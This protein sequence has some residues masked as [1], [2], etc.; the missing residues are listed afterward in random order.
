MDDSAFYC[1]KL[2]WLAA[3]RSLGFAVDDDPNPK[4]SFWFSPKQFLYSRRV[5]RLNDPGEYATR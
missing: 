4:R 3:M 1:S 2:A 5:A